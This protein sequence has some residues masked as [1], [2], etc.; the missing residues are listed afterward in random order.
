MVTEALD[1]QYL[2]LDNYK[3]LKLTEEE[4]AVVLMINH[5][6][7]S[8]NPFVTADLL[9]I[10]MNLDIKKID[11][12][13][14]SLLARKYIK[15]ETRNRQ[16]V[17]TLDP[18]K[19]LLFKQFQLNSLREEKENNDKRMSEELPNIYG[20]F[21]Q[22]LNRTLSPL[23]LSRIREWVQLGY[24]D[25]TIVNALKEAL[26]RKRKSFNEIDKILLAW[27]QRDDIES[28]GHTAIDTDWDKNIEETIRI[29]KTPW[30][31]TDD[32]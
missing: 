12:I 25:E 28:E 31:D 29:A 10:K 8:D 14:A 24:D 26:S 7:S 21:E 6:I 22:I 15:Y 2:L 17:T 3:K 20:Q 18:L 30:L 4:L 5:L 11:K 19:K 27:A 1:F 9:S 13:M 16:T 32:D 23:E